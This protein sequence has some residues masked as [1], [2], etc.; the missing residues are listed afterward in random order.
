MARAVVIVLLVLLLVGCATVPRVLY[1]DHNPRFML[2]GMET[3]SAGIFLV[4]LKDKETNKEFTII[5]VGGQGV[6]I[7]E[8]R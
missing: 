7:L 2:M 8:M 1:S 6:G 5:I 4:T 3:L